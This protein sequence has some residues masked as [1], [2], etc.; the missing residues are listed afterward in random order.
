MNECQRQSISRNMCDMHYARWL[1]SAKKEHTYILKTS[2]PI[3]E[4]LCEHRKINLENGCWEWTGSVTSFGYGYFCR[5]I[6]GKRKVLLA[7]R[8]SALFW[9]G[10]APK[11]KPLACHKCDNPLCF[12]PQHLFWGSSSDNM[13]DSSKKKRYYYAKGGD[14]KRSSYDTSSIT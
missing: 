3:N 6:N 12:N 5:K 10:P 9:L 11:T 14:C 13:K 1:R 8:L 4:Q 2:R 7:H